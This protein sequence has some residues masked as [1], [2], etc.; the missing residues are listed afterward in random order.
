MGRSMNGAA[1]GGYY[2]RVRDDLLR[3]VAA[4]LDVVSWLGGFLC[5]QIHLVARAGAP[6]AARA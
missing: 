2:G 6:A 1:D 3:L 5:G 4:A